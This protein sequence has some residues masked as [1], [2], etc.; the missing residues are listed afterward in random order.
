MRC[1]WRSLLSVAVVG[2]LGGVG[3]DSEVLAANSGPSLVWQVETLDGKALESRAEDRTINPASVVKLA[4]SLRALEMLGHEHRFTT[5]FAVVTSVGDG[6]PARQT[7]LVVNGGADPDFHFENAVLIAHELNEAGVQG[8]G[9]DLFVGE[10]FW[11]GWERGTA[12]RETDPLKRRQEMALRLM[13]AW[14]PGKWTV[15]QRKSWGEVAERRGW[16]KASEPTVRIDGK[17]RTDVPA[18]GGRVVVEHRSE[19]LITA[20]RRFNVFSNNDIERLDDSTGPASELASFFQSRWGT[21]ADGMSFSTTSGL[22]RN[23]MTPVQIVRVVRETRAWLGQRKLELADLMPVLGCG[24]ST[25]S[26]LFP[27]LRES[28]EANGLIGKTG[29][30][31]TQDGGV[32][33]L[34][35]FIPIG[36]G[37]V[38]VVAA[39]GAGRVLRQARAAEE[40]WV[41]RV[42]LKHGSVEP[43]HCQEPVPTSDA[44]AVISGSAKR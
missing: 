38:F 11:I 8:V 44:Q 32:S 20:L 12:G 4:A 16:D 30:L 1:L 18:G 29:T 21:A 7:G 17:L 34:A 33:A 3:A 31:N 42:L 9:G 40:D 6:E 28:G 24:T 15:E 22:N 23:R 35:G 36:N 25:L 2:V 41:R 39:P 43:L 19:P 27:R 26:E 37:L 5:T 10:G 13:D 14:T